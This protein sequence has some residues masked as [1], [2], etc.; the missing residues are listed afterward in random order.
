MFVAKMFKLYI[1]KQAWDLNKFKC[2]D[3]NGFKQKKI[4]VREFS[5]E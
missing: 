2:K 4:K 5:C 3:E 1:S